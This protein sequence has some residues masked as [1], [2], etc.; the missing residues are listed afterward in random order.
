MGRF[1]LSS[2]S[3]SKRLAIAVSNVIGPPFIELYP[4]HNLPTVNVNSFSELFRFI[5]TVFANLFIAAVIRTMRTVIRV[6]EGFALHIRP[7]FP[8]FEVIALL[9]DFKDVMVRALTA[10]G[11]PAHIT[12]AIHIPIGTF[13]TQFPLAI[14]GTLTSYFID[15]VAPLV[16]C[17]FGVFVNTPATVL[18][19]DV[20]FWIGLF[21]QTVWRVCVM[22]VVMDYI[23]TPWTIGDIVFVTQLGIKLLAATG[24]SPKRIFHGRSIHQFLLRPSGWRG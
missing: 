17:F 1:S 5:F 23:A 21:K 4:Y 20:V 22:D 9:T 6:I 7:K 10:G 14:P 2:V 16:L 19:V 8:F 12:F 24:A 13:T 18:A 3:W 11:I 15:P